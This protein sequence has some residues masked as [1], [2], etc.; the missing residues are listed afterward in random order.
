[1]RGIAKTPEPPYYAVI[2]ASQ[3]T[4]SDNGYGTMSDKMIEL[5][6]KQK[7]FLGVESA[8]DEELGITVSYWDSLESI[9]AWKDNAAHK[10]AQNKGK[11]EWYKNFSLRVCKV[12]RHN[13]FEM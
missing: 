5:A 10:I 9:K 13:F 3:R 12:E 8:R 2:F 7:G 11:T 6:S 1:M 4:E